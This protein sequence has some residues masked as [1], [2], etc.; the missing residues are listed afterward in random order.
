MAARKYRL[1]ILSLF[2]CLLFFCGGVQGVLAQR[3]VAGKPIKTGFWKGHEIEYVEGRINLKL[4]SGYDK[5]DILPLF[6]EHEMDIVQDFDKLRWALVEVPPHVDIFSL[7]D[8]LD[9][10]PMVEAVE[11]DG[12]MH[13]FLDPNDPSFTDGTQWAL[14]NTG[15]DPPGGAMDADIDAPEA[16]DITLGSSSVIIAILDSGIPMQNGSLSHPDLGLNNPSR[17]ILGPDLIELNQKNGVMDQFGHGTH[18]T[19]IA[20]A[21]TDN[22]EGVAGVCGECKVMVVQDSD[23]T[24]ASLWSSF[25]AG[26]IYAVDNGAD[27][28][29]Y[30]G[31]NTGPFDPDTLQ[32]IEDAVAYANS[33][34]VTFVAAVGNGPETSVAYPAKFSSQYDNVIAVSATDHI[35]DRAGYSNSGP[36]VNVAAPGGDGGPE[37]EDDIYSTTPNYAFTLET[38]TTQTY[39]YLAGTSMS[40]PHVTGTVGLMLSV[41]NTLLPNQIRAILEQTA[42]DVFFDGFDEQTGHG[43][44]N[45]YEALKYTL[46]NYGG[47]LS[48]EVLLT[49]NLT[50]SSGAVLTVEEGTTIKFDPGI[51]L[52][53]NG[54]LNV[55]GQSGSEVTFTRSG[56]SGTWDGI[57]FQTGSSGTIAYATVDHATKGVYV[58]DTDNVTIDNCT[59]Q[60]FTEQGI[61]A[62]NSSLTVQNSMIHLPAGA[63][64]GIYL[65]G[66][67]SHPTITGNTID[68]IAIGI[69]R[70]D[71]PGAATISNN[72]IQT[73]N[74]G[75]KTHLSAPEIY[76]NYV[77]RSVFHGIRLATS[78]SPDIHD[79][80]IFDNS[81]GVLLEQSEP[82]RL[83]WNNIGWSNGDIQSN[84]DG[85]LYIFSLSSGNSFMDFQGN[86]FYDGLIKAD[87]RNETSETLMARGNFWYDFSAT[88]PIDASSPLSSHNTDAGPGGAL[89]KLAA[90]EPDS[91]SEPPAPA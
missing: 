60:N 40:T 70:K 20:A 80:D 69:E 42:D 29:N 73:C 46:E 88:G 38:E 5:T 17:F 3:M 24:G 90:A 6:S 49:E 65:L 31:G 91:E 12:V 1:P 11:P 84:Q 59:I 85:G 63:S 72:T 77:E 78:S 79:N 56:T 28:I 18:V 74:D 68:D 58:S 61:Y 10:H 62:D 64:H 19:G 45:A 7:M 54:T 26:V 43:R 57:Q 35:D 76:N 36:E 16:W 15:Q 37:D 27:V 8:A 30:S 71:S 2:A 66:D 22:N 47:T 33:N 55:N 50:I 41:N 87:V 23:S 25:K 48:G 51:K 81:F 86:N 52:T 89:G 75:I 44:I 39:G 21:K 53:I 13:T 83:K 82:S 4:K 67:D 32:V 34:N 14:H 9:K